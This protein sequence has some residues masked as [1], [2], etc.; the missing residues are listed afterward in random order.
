[1]SPDAALSPRPPFVSDPEDGA[2]QDAL[3]R[4]RDVLSSLTAIQRA[5]TSRRPLQ[6]V[7]DAIITAARQLLGDEQPALYLFDPED[8]GWLDLV[9]HENLPPD[10]YEEIKRR[11]SGVGVAGR[12]AR[13]GKLVVIE[14]YARTANGTMETFRT[15]GMTGAMAAPVHEEG[16]VIGSLLVSTYAPGRV[17]SRTEREVLIALA[18]HASL[19]LND[20]SVVREMAHQALHDPL[21][22]L[23]NRTLLADRLQHAR[24][25]ARRNGNG[26]AVLFC[27]LDRFKTVNDSLGHAVG[28][29]LLGHVSRRIEGCLRGGDTA[30]RV[31]GDEFAILLEDITSAEEAQAVAERVLAALRRPFV[32]GGRELFAHA[33]IGVSLAF[34]ADDAD[35]LRRADVAMYRAKADGRGRS[36]MFEPAM[37]LAAIEQV[38]LEADLERAL[39]RGEL[40]VHYQP[41]VELQTGAVT[42]FEALARWR[43]PVR[44]LLGADAF[45]PL[46][47]D[48]GRLPA[49]GRQ[50]LREACDALALWRREMPSAR[51]SSVNVNLSARELAEPDLVSHVAMALQDSGLPAECLTLEITEGSLVGDTPAMVAR[52]E[53]L[54]GLGV[55]L[56]V[57]DFGT[58]YSA[59]RYLSVLPVDVLKMAKPFVDDVQRGGRDAA[60]CGAI[61]DL[62]ANL[63][64]EVVAE[65]IE[66]AAQADLLRGLGCSHGQG[67]HFA[68]PLTARDLVAHLST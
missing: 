25:R 10:I 35:L 23:P 5:I 16:R 32:L 15:R 9:A 40:E 28:D 68:K 57:D 45:I 26:V 48:T 53:E 44:G 31:G 59:L 42:G 56:A 12:A 60:L 21:T 50:V 20:A 43:H 34:G 55:R 39:G 38:M 37:Q 63:G 18:E 51:L 14:D 49:I 46:A 24:E 8:S 27:D 36:V 61:V 11:P 64:L 29:E 52:L 3:Q 22:G 17:Y 2:L 13:E 65:G 47:E 6:D 33:S 7:L 19:A 58:G 4:H 1:M 62:A 66:H 41:I 30:A 54:K 67:Y